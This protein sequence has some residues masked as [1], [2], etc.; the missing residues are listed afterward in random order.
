MKALTL[1]SI[2]FA[3]TILTAQEQAQ[4]A[5][6]AEP[7]PSTGGFRR[8]G[9]APRSEMRPVVLPDQIV[10][11]AGTIIA[12]RVNDPLSSD[13]NQPGDQFTATLTQPVIGDGFVVARRGQ[14][15]AGRVAE[16]VRAGRAKGTS[17]LAIEL[18]EM[19]VADGR[20]VPMVTQLVQFAGGTSKGRDATAVG[21]TA[22]VGA[23]IGA[24]AEGG[25]GAGIGAAAGAAAAGIGVL[26]TR[27]RATEIWP[28]S[29][30]TF[31][32]VS[33][34]TINTERAPHAF[35]QV[36]QDD[37]EQRQQLQRRPAQQ[38]P[39]LWGGYPMWGGPGLWW[40]GYPYSYWGGPGWGGG[41]GYSRWGSGWGWG[42][43]RGGRRR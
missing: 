30:L 18:T 25:A 37:Y 17:R 27:G 29:Q 15:L 12:L 14:M 26:L 1:I 43:H 13:R 4:P 2:T 20:Q 10:L 11:P 31:R 36:R 6:P 5:A 21:T 9:E 24:A 16:A 39:T 35:L 8:V 33:P 3:A 22:G 19:Q 41:F 28:E 42:G 40:G 32:L 23:M 7:Q 34:L 38:P